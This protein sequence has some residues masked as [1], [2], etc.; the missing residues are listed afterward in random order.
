MGL[1]FSTSSKS[2]RKIVIVGSGYTAIKL[3][4][5]LKQYFKIVKC[6]SPTKTFYHKVGALRGL[7]VDKWEEDIELPLNGILADDEIIVGKASEIQDKRIILENGTVIV[8]DICVVAIGSSNVLGDLTLTPFNSSSERMNAWSDLRQLVMK[9]KKIA[10]IGGGFVGAEAA[11]ELTDC[12]DKKEITLI[13]GGATLLNSS[14][15]QMYPKAYTDVVHEKMKVQGVTVCLNST[16]DI[17][18]TFTYV[19]KPYVSVGPKKLL[20]SNKNGTSMS[21]DVDLVLNATGNKINTIKG[22]PRSTNG[23]GIVVDDYFRVQG[24]T[25][26]FAVGDCACTK[27]VMKMIIGLTFHLNTVIPMILE[28]DKSLNESEAKETKIGSYKPL[29]FTPG[30]LPIGSKNGAFFLPLFGGVVLPTFLI[31]FLKS[32]G[33][34]LY[35]ILFMNSY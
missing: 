7:V 29:T 23:Q 14:A 13:H 22:L 30:L 20:V 31:V 26:V 10:V 18:D 6:I 8:F 17:A 25:N 4:S 21:L 11:G 3:I 35:L 16:I 33:K 5:K 15:F 19:K 27:D 12:L 32:N 2:D 24:F 9:S 1:Q 28:L 34:S